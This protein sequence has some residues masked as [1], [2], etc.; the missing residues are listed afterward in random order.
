VTPVPALRDCL[1]AAGPCLVLLIGAAGA[2][3]STLAAQL[4]TGEHQVLSLDGLRAAVSGDE[5]DQDSTP[6]AAAALH[7]LTGARLR[8]GLTTIIDATNVE[9]DARRP[10]LDMARRHRMPALAV[11][12]DTPLATCLARNERRPGPPPG[13]RWGRR[14]PPPVVRAQHGQLRDALPALAAEGFA[15]VLHITD[16]GGQGPLPLVP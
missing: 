3:K 15:Q 8:R 16:A 6:D 10:L 9:A 7:L 13:A 4:A 12:V 1:A 5:S 2:G 11:V 14:V